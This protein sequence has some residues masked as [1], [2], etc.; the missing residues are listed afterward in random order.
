MTTRRERLE[1]KLQRRIEWSDKA[2][3]RAEQSFARSQSLVAG[4]PMG[5]PI[6]V[7]HHSERADRNRRDKSWAALGRSVAETKLS[8]HHSYKAQNLAHAL[9]RTIFSDDE[10]AVEALEQRIA[11][12]EA[13]RE[14]M[15]KINAMYRKGDAAGLAAVGLDL[16]VLRA[17]LATAYS[18]CQQP[19]PGYELQNLGQRIAADKKRLESVKAQQT[20]HD[21]AAATESGVAVVEHSNGYCSVTFAE[22]PE[23]DIL[24]DLRGAGY[25][26]GAGHWFGQTE[27]L[28][29][30]VRDLAAP[31]SSHSQGDE[32][33]E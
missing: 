3:Q 14:R 33:S 24:R 23:R 10:N 32:V 22:K 25:R 27:K 30:S 13:Q 2:E 19:H 26:W 17:K 4:I 28:P 15:K 12:H 5:Q 1:N 29:S 21:A 7:G 6:L 20:R 31:Q 18:W 9:K 8:A 16:E 11:A